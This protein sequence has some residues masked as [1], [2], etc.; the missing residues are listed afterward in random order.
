MD[1]QVLRAQ[2]WLNQ[3]YGDNPLF[4]GIDEDGITG[5]FMFSALTEAWQIE[6]RKD[7]PDLPVTGTFASMTKSLSPSLE[8][9]DQG[10]M[11]QILQFALLCKGYAVYD[12]DGYFGVQT[13]DAVITLQ[14]EAG[15]DDKTVY[16]ASPLVEQAIFSPE[17]YV[18]VARGDSRIRS[19]QQ[20]LNYNYLD[21][22]GIGPCDGIFSRF[23]AEALIYALQ[24]EEQLPTDVANGNFGPTTT[25]C[26]P[27]IPYD[28]EAT[29][30]YGDYY[31]TTTISNCIKIIQY[32][33]YCYG[34]GEYDSLS[35]DYSKYDPGDFNGEFN[36]ETKAAL[37]VFQQDVGLPERDLVGKNEWM[38]L[39]V[40]TGNP[41]RDG[42]ACDCAEKIDTPAKAQAIINDEYSVV[43]RYLTGT[44]YDANYV[45][46][47]KALDE[48]EL[49]TLKE[50]GLKVFSIY[51]DAKEWYLANPDQEDIH[52]YYDY[53]Q[54]IIDA[55][56]ATA[57]ALN[58]KV[59][60]GEYIYFAVDY[61]FYE[62]EV[63]EMIIPYFQGIND[64]AAA[65]FMP[66][67]IGIYGARNT[68]TLVRK[69]GLSSSSFVS[70][71][72]TGYSGN[73][74]FPLPEDWAFDQVKEYRLYYSGGDFGIDK[75]VTSGRYMGF[76]PLQDSPFQ[77]GAV[78]NPVT[79][80]IYPIYVEE[81]FETVIQPPY[82]YEE[83]SDEMK[84]TDLGQINFDGVKFL[85][86]LSL[87]NDWKDNP[88]P[89]AG[90]INIPLGS[91]LGLLIGGVLSLVDSFSGTQIRISYYRV[92]GQPNKKVIIH[93][94]NTQ[95]RSLFSGWNYEFPQSFKSIRYNDLTWLNTMNTFAKE[96][97]ELFKGVTA[98]DD[99]D[100]DIYVTLNPARKGS[101]YV[102][103][104]FLGKEGRMYEYFTLYPGEKFEIVVTKKS[105]WDVVERFD[106][107][108]L[109]SY[110]IEVSEEVRAL[111]NIQTY[112]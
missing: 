87:M 76:T 9:G 25:N 5:S 102:T 90:R 110:V 47:S 50:A 80:E 81:N 15:L 77:Y 106:F 51:Q 48:Q 105:S 3:N 41:D 93:C 17:Y 12:D 88:F 78:R 82:E 68:C 57:A 71:L 39:L 59:P 79:G 96:Q 84:P 63:E 45:P 52:Y 37:H 65:N 6:L 111:F 112:S 2:Q 67:S 33:L 58:L 20:S 31:S 23:T 69:A 4:S 99:Y 24:A 86:G 29:S 10:V 91:I 108:E 109:I 89:G 34:H 53:E 14:Y 54:G 19:I 94:G 43:G 100:Y 64:Y 26:L 30:Y 42:L 103:E 35:P 98:S 60:I 70:D 40:S 11:V 13:R 75:N 92:P 104:L 85:A 36:E 55:R 7:N 83:N 74:G 1:A 21:Y 49:N 61:D 101:A 27:T 72:S 66:Y 46:V 32:A 73:L 38:A 44:I 8:L 18:K 16:F 62:F 56:K 28:N 22:I 97:Y 107:T 95:Y